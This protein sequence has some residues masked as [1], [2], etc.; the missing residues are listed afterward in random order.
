MSDSFLELDS[1]VVEITRRGITK[2]YKVVELSAW[3][4]TQL[5]R[6][7]EKLFDEPDREAGRRM[8][9]VARSTSD[10][11]GNRVWTDDDAKTLSTKSGA[12]VNTLWLAAARLSGFV[13][14][15]SAKNSE[16]SPSGTSA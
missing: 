11:S 2:K 12:V 3:E 5:W 16:T 1:E 10:E 13:K 7:A 6:D 15:D 4:S 8:L 9:L 14:D